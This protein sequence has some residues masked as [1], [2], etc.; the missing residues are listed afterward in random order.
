[1]RILENETSKLKFV[2]NLAV[3]GFSLFGVTRQDVNFKKST[4][5]EKLMIDSLAPMQRSI[6]Y[7]KRE[8]TT[9]FE[10]YVINVSASKKNK[11][12]HKKISQLNEKIFLYEEL[13]KENI[14]LKDLMRFGE[15]ISRNKVLAE[16]VAWDSSSDFKMLRINKGVKHGI[17][18][19]SIVV[20]QDGLVGY[21]YRMTDNFADILTVL[22][23]NNRIDGI[24]E[25]TRSHGIIEGFTRGKCV[26]KYVTRTG[27]VILNDHVLTSGLGNIYPKGVKIGAVSRI[28]RESYGITQHIEVVPSV[29]FSRLEEVVVL[30]S[31]KRKK[32]E[33]E[34]KALDDQGRGE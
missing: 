8:L 23:P 13:A 7:L 27:P 2:I 20:T 17:K 12:L 19:Q 21:V 29:D 3:I 14:R 1:M 4:M 30:V 5:F 33:I 11:T 24:I 6:T 16:V 22:D 28:E 9:V 31:L 26:M 32:R 18:L 34:W 15:G 25:R 10:D